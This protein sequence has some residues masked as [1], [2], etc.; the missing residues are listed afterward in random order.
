MT[1]I[2]LSN[3]LDVLEDLNKRFPR[4]DIPFYCYANSATQVKIKE[5]FK[6]VII[7]DSPSFSGLPI[8]L[9]PIPNGEVQIYNLDNELMRTVIIK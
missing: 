8:Y 4:K 5:Y 7:N 9:A 3:L 2:T 6:P 1:D